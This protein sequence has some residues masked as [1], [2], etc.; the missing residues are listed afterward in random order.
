MPARDRDDDQ[1]ENA[2]GDSPA[3]APANDPRSWTAET[4][5]AAAGWTHPLPDALIAPLR[6]IAEGRAG[7]TCRSPTCA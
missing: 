3:M 4:V 5:G 6:S 1:V 7:A 2:F